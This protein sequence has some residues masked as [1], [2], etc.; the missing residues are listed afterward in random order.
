M[1]A[2]LVRTTLDSTVATPKG[3]IIT[4]PSPHTPP[5]IRNPNLK[6]SGKRS[7]P[8]PPSLMCEQPPST[9]LGLEFKG[10]SVSD[11]MGF[12]QIFVFTFGH[13]VYRLR[14]GRV[15]VLFGVLD[16][17]P[18]AVLTSRSLKWHVPLLE[19]FCEVPQPQTQNPKP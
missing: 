19:V 17:T 11:F 2:R 14:T 7:P 10:N 3:P 1:V 4:G 12:A 5:K 9:L 15:C 8:T 16:A 6:A 18:S 13:Q